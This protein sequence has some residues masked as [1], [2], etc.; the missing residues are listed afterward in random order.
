MFQHVPVALVVELVTDLS[1]V[2]PSAGWVCRVLRET[3][4]VLAGVEKLI[5]TL[6]AAAHILHVDETGAKVTGARWWLH[7]SATEKLTTYHLDQSRGRPA[8]TNLGIFDGVTG[9][10]VHDCWASCN[11]YTDCEHALCG[12]HIAREL[13]AAD[14]THRGQYWQ[15]KP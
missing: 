12:A 8:I 4:D 9:I 5:R 11:A 6:L 15:P 14:E 13:I 10:A 7:V 1:G 3:A 2:D